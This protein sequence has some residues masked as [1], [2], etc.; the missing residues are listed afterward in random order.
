MFCFH[1]WDKIEDP[2]VGPVQYCKKCGKVRRVKCT[3]DTHKWKTF[4]VYEKTYT[5][6]TTGEQ[7]LAGQ[8]YDQQCEYCGKIQRIHP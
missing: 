1:K 5:N 8:V 3:K 4:K 7:E 2:K 6:L